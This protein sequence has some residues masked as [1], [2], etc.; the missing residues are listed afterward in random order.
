M[1]K[2]TDVKMKCPECTLIT[3]V[4][5]GIPDIDGDGG[6]GCPRCYYTLKKEIAMVDFEPQKIKLE[7]SVVWED[8]ECDPNAAIFQLQSMMQYLLDKDVNT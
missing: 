4:G 8:P 6:I 3:T 1:Q 5:E 7:A 2:I